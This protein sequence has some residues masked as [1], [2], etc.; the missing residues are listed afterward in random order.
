MPE[1]IN[2]YVQAHKPDESDFRKFK[3]KGGSNHKRTNI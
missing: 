2:Q 1:L 3:V